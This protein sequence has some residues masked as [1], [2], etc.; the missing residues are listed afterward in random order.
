M[1]RFLS[2]LMAV[3]MALSVVPMSVFATEVRTIYWDPVTGADS[4]SGRAE[5]APVKTKEAAYAAL[6][7]ADAGILVLLS[8]LNLTAL[9]N[10]PTCNIP[11]TITSKT[12]AEGIASSANINFNGETKLEK[13]FLL[14]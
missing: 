7:G 14:A 8:T 12:G 4:N 13:L 5:N 6:S 9:T 1:K 3:I 11:V 2:L 10:F